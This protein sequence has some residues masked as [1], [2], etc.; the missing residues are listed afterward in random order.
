MDIFTKILEIYGP[1][2]SIFDFVFRLLKERDKVK[3]TFDEFE[4]FDD[5]MIVVY[6][7]VNESKRKL[8]LKDAWFLYESGEFV[9]KWD[10]VI[11]EEDWD[12]IDFKKP[13]VL[14][15]HRSIEIMYNKAS[16][17]KN[18]L[19]PESFLLEEENGKR[20]FLNSKYKNAA[21]SDLRAD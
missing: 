4:S 1:V 14:Q 6:K 11:N 19:S 7:I 12:H 17:D 8:Y 2:H 13:I 16:L 18:E 15:P 5:R 20:H 21:P 3:I 9:G 10:S